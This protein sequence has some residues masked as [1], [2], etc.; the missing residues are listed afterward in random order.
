MEVTDKTL[1]DVKGGTLVEC[2]GDGNDGELML[3]EIAQAR[4]EHVDEFKSVEKFK[5]FNTNNLWLN[6]E[7]IKKL[8]ES[9]TLQLDIIINE[10]H[11]DSGN[12]C[13]SRDEILRPSA[14]Y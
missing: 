4:K 5:I 14:Q 9:K 13:G 12:S 2:G 8:V 7:N 6:L 3:L 1:A 11:L 10:K